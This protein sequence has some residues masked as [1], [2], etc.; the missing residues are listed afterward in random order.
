MLS[1]AG[2][3]VG[4]LVRDIVMARL[5]ARQKREQE[6]QDRSQAAA[7]A[8]LNDVRTYADPLYEAARSLSFRLDEI[9]QVRN[10]GY[11]L[12]GAPATTFIDYK[13]LSTS[14]RLASLLGWI[15]AFRRERSYLDAQGHAE[16]EET[17]GAIA[18]IEAALADGQHVEDSRLL[19]LMSL[20][21]LDPSSIADT[22]L[23]IQLATSIE[24]ERHRAFGDKSNWST[25]GLNEMEGAELVRGCANFLSYALK[26]D[27]PDELVR[28]TTP[29]ALLYLNIRE[30]YIYRDWQAAIGDFM[31][32]EASHGPRRFEVRGFGSFEDAYLSSRSGENMLQRRWFDRLE[33]LFFNL[34]MSDGNIFDARRAQIK[35]LFEELKGLEAVLSRKLDALAAA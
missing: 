6:I 33:A 7:S 4:L 23:R 35:R 28:S 2:V 19:D 29:A 30:A 3:L 31:I 34:D 17:Q 13:R 1:L 20:W 21:H 16:G 11:L 5:L 18:K 15:R 8:R 26:A 27:I 9:I 14:Y 22:R 32:V 24:A 25:E 10:P 12:S